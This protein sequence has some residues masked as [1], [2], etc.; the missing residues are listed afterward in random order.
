M[1]ESRR[2]LCTAAFHLCASTPVVAATAAAAAS[3]ARGW[4]ASTDS[5]LVMGWG[6]RRALR[7][8]RVARR[9]RRARRGATAAWRA[10]ER[11]RR[12]QA[13]PRLRRRGGRV[14]EAPA[15]GTARADQ[16]RAPPQWKRR[17][18]AA[19]RADSRRRAPLRAPKR[20]ARRGARRGTRARRTA[21]RRWR[22]GHVARALPAVHVCA[23]A[24]APPRARDGAR[25]RLQIVQCAAPPR[26]P[27]FALVFGAA[28]ARHAARATC[29]VRSRAAARPPAAAA[30][31]A[32]A[33]APAPPPA[34][35]QSARPSPPCA[36][37]PPSTP[38]ASTLRPAPSLL[39]RPTPPPFPSAPPPPSLLPLSLPLLPPHPRYAFALRCPPRRNQTAPRRAVAAARDAAGLGLR[40]LVAIASL[41]CKELSR[42][43]TL[44]ITP[45][46]SPLSAHASSEPPSAPPSPM[47]DATDPPVASA[48]DVMDVSPTSKNALSPHRVA[49]NHATDDDRQPSRRPTVDNVVRDE[50]LRSTDAIAPDNDSHPQLQQSSSIL[51]APPK[52]PPPDPVHDS[53]FTYVLRAYNTI[54]DQRVYSPY[55]HFGGFRW[56]LLI[57]PKGNLS[58]N[59][60]LSVYLECGGPSQRS[61]HSNGPN[62]N[63]SIVTNITSYAWGRPAKFWLVLLHP[64]SPSAVAALSSPQGVYTLQSAAADHIAQQ[65]Q[66]AAEDAAASATHTRLEIVKEA[67]HNFKET[68]S[69]WGFLE[70][71]PFTKLQPGKYADDHMNVFIQVRI[72]LQESAPEPVSSAITP[73]DSRKETGFVGFKN[74]G[75]TC[76]MNSLLQTLYMVSAFRKAVYNMPLPEP[77]NENSGSE[78]SYALQKVFYELQ[79]SP[80]VVK[81]KKLTESFGWDTTD[82]FTQHDVQ[83]LKLILCDELAERMK[84]IAPDKPNTLSTLFQ[85]KLL[86]YVECVNVD[87]ASTTEEEFS[88]LS[89]NVK[90]CRNIYESFEKYMEVEM[91]EGDNKYRA[92]GFDELQEARKGVKFLKL[93]PVLQLHLKRFE[94]DLTRY[95]MVKIN[96]R[97]EF[98]SEIDLSRFVEKSD[99]TDVYVLHSVLVHIGDVNGGHYHAFIRPYIDVNNNDTKKPG[100]WF[101][102]DDETVQAATEEQAVQDNFGMGGERDLP[103]RRSGM[104][105]DLTGVNGGQNP[106]H[107]V[108][109]QTRRSN[110]QTR[111]CS[112]A[113]MLQ[114]LRKSEVPYLLKPPQAS[115][116][117]KALAAKIEKEREEDAKRQQEKAE[118]HL[119]MNIAVARDQD[120]VEHSGSDLVNWD[121]VHTMRV[122]RTVQLGDLKQRLQKEGLVQDARR[123][124]LWRC[125]SG[126]N[127]TNRPDSLVAEGYENREITEPNP[128]DNYIHPGY[129]YSLYSVRHG[130][131]GQD[132]VVHM[133]AEDLCSPFCLAPGQ[134]YNAYMR[135]LQELSDEMKAGSLSPMAISDGKNPSVMETEALRNK[136][137][138]PTF[139]L[140][141][142]KEVLL[143]LK[144]Y[145]PRPAPRLQW[146]GHFIVDRSVLVRDLH[147]L[148]RR[149]LAQYHNK[150][151]SLP[152]VEEHLG[153]VAYE[154]ESAH[155]I[156]ELSPDK[157][158]L[159]QSI[160][161]ETNNGDIIVFQQALPMEN[162]EVEG[163][164]WDERQN[165]SLGDGTDLPLGGRPLPLVTSYFEYLS[166]RIKI[167]FKDKATVGTADEVKSIFFELLRRD[168]YQTARRV[169]AGAL[170]DDV[171]PDYLRFFEHNQNTPASEPVNLGDEDSL[172]RIVPMHALLTPGQTDHRMIWY[173]RTEYHISDFNENDEIRVT[174]RPDGGARLVS[175]STGSNSPSGG[176]T[177]MDTGST[178]ITSG[179][180]SMRSERLDDGK[181]ISAAGGEIEKSLA[182]STPAWQMYME[183]SRTFSVLVPPSS[184]Y[185]DLAGEV[186]RKL[187]VPSS[188]QIR[189]FEIKNCRILK[190]IS[191][192]EVIPPI[193][194]AHDCGA[195]LRA[196]PV[197]PEETDEGLGEDYELMTVLHLAK[198]RQPR[199]WRGLSFFGNPFVIKLKKSGE[200]VRNIRR[201][202]QK[203]LGIPSSEFDEWPL[204]ECVQA[205]VVYL[206][207]EDQLYKRQ[208]RQT[209]EF[210]TLAVEHKSL[211]PTRRTTLSRYAD[212]PLK[213]RS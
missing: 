130:Y 79:T 13:A 89:L 192:D 49:V 39:S 207:D 135:N 111:R 92:D 177:S 181:P 190:I 183:G 60:D 103:K 124:R 104:D 18:H 43:D 47:D 3:A 67:V 23:R 57:F 140:A 147:T 185:S 25:R 58:S 161:Y 8:R 108:F 29:L 179:D 28:A 191:P 42:N 96:D 163:F 213:I 2:L 150:D 198:D 11:A 144:Y 180:G 88:D 24:G 154:E 203:K 186:R 75:A 193:M 200:P 97:F 160:P 159:Q 56:R 85:G 33:P 16:R 171:D 116:V 184:K 44:A 36:P 27:L 5:A 121:R 15:C 145:T 133:Y 196:E 90:G 7:N 78:L 70:F 134:A 138:I 35:P 175:N 128:R 166:Q 182:T 73:L 137:P 115:D 21:R 98:A 19:A 202:I 72:R 118:Q 146:L 38:R 9:Q 125:V 51:N 164:A 131:Y 165:R 84:K 105:D 83:E 26:S 34:R 99:G 59:H 162:G 158:L 212:K 69:D 77:G 142:G 61:T 6:W 120:M 101:K 62:G 172:D 155:R 129:N 156:V 64:S 195:E 31:E 143:F 189:M 169:L 91:M 206:D 68:A 188:V 199:V 81:T 93:P 113:Y 168:T 174:W 167:E 4:R 14:E 209:N 53:Q 127:D 148:F 40:G 1:A 211:A 173:E 100:Q 65:Q 157:S 110:Y 201:R 74:Q 151:R 112:N 170:G 139:P 149:A 86:N 117:P 106:P 178:N 54:H 141:Y 17:V 123:I 210:C 205:T 46:P 52:S 10:L 176:T 41:H 153:L 94:Y 87:Y 37:A 152:L 71:A 20:R 119:Y 208:V 22:A 32:P 187:S 55:H 204:C 95:T 82:A 197:P 12:A 107:N 76:Y 122:R 109:P 45:P 126:D 80:T 102:F 136:I 114:Y 48:L 30:A 50:Q 194:T 66:A 132:E 63:D